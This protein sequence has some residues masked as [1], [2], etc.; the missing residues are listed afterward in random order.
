M[1]EHSRCRLIAIQDTSIFQQMIL[2]VPDGT[3]RGRFRYTAF[4]DGMVVSV[5]CRE[6]IIHIY[7]SDLR[8]FAVKP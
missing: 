2:G 8:V 7:Q 6:D 1:L 3:G 5:R 4:L